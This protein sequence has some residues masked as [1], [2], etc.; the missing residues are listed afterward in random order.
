[1]VSPTTFKGRVH[2]RSR[3]KLTG[4]VRES[5]HMASPATSKGWGAPPDV[6]TSWDQFT[7]PSRVQNAELWAYTPLEAMSKHMSCLDRS[8]S[9]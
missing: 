4:F 6:A 2:L 5:R 1:M 9:S 8:P 3:F 7:D